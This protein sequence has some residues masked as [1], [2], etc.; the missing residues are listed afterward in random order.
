[1]HRKED[2]LSTSGRKITSICLGIMQTVE[3]VNEIPIHFIY[4]LNIYQVIKIC[5]ILDQDLEKRKLNLHLKM[6]NRVGT[7]D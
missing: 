4:S 5:Q 3:E 1:M 7:T 6:L 2:Y